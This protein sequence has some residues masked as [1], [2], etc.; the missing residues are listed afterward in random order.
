MNTA[1]IL[2]NIII[3]NPYDGYFGGTQMYLNHMLDVM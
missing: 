3:C 2:I 1:I